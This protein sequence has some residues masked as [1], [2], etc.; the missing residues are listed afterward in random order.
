MRKTVRIT[1]PFPKPPDV[2]RFLGIS[3]SRAKQLAQLADS[4]VAE[5]EP[6]EHRNAAPSKRW[7]SKCKQI[8]KK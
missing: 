4:I 3:R 5:Q 1:T 7:A 8:A 2:A 6:E